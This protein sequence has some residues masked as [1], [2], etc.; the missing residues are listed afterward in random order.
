MVLGA[1]VRFFRILRQNAYKAWITE[2]GDRDRLGETIHETA[3]DVKAEVGFGIL[4]IIVSILSII[5]FL[6]WLYDRWKVKPPTDCDL[7]DVEAMACC[8]ISV[9]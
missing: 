5:Q 9:H 8:G 6:T 1:R 2:N 3:R 4:G 7:D